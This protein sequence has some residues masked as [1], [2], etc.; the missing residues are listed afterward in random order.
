MDLE[1]KTYDIQPAFT[2]ESMTIDKHDRKDLNRNKHHKD[3]KK[4]SHKKKHSKKKSRNSSGELEQSHSSGSEHDVDLWVEKPTAIAATEQETVESL[5]NVSS[6]HESESLPVARADWMTLDDSMDIFGLA[7]AAPDRK[8]LKHLEREAE[9]ARRLAIRKERELNPT[10]FDDPANPDTNIVKSIEI[11]EN[12]LGYTFGD[13]GANWRMAKLKRIF[14]NSK[15]GQSVDSMALERYGTMEAFQ[16]ALDER[17]FLDKAKGVK[18]KD[19]LGSYRPS[20]GST[21]KFQRP[22]ESNSSFTIHQE[23]T[24][25]TANADK[26]SVDQTRKSVIPSAFVPVAQQSGSESAYAGE[27]LSHTQLNRLNAQVIKARLMRSPN[28]KAL[29]EEYK[30]SKAQSDN[31]AQREKVEIVPNIDSRGRLYDLNADPSQSKHSLKRHKSERDTHDTSSNRIQSSHLEEQTL[32]DLVLQEKMGSGTTF[33]QDMADRISRDT[34]FKDSLDYMDESVDK[35]AQKKV[36]S[37]NSK[38][39]FAIDNYKKTQS[40]IAKCNFC[41]HEGEAPRIPIV[42]LGTEV[43]LSLPETIDMVP[44]HCLIVPVQ[45]SLTTLE[46]ED[47]AWNEIRNFQKSLLRMA[48][49]NN[50]GVIFMEQVI[51][52]KSH[53]HTV[54]ECI[55]VPMNLFEDAPA[56]YKEAINNVEEEWSQHKKLIVTDRGFRRSMV[57]NLPYFHVWFDPNRGFGHVIENS[58]EWLPWFGREVIAS[59]LDLPTYTWRKPKRANERDNAQRLD[60]FRTQWKEYDWT[61]LLD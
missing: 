49:A 34:T 43:Y 52:F 57:P 29:E 14:D 19:S 22:G 5:T 4:K 41:F 15:E 20:I 42:S 53:K 31:A 17:A 33:D 39:Q 23:Q 38:R 48:S 55:P 59:V 28:L 58:E 27:V 32:E 13:R 3:H 35:L 45:H 8:S 1:Q 37:S 10:Y 21:A 61:K 51:N 60:Q 50:Q 16:M 44:G 56:Y 12:K 6:I 54:I 2:G 46:L 47:N 26:K 24:K 7:K 25:V 9:E 18:S 11:K 30:R 36:V 40:T